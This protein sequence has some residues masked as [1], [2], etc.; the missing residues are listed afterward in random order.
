MTLRTRLAFWF[1]GLLAITIVFFSIAVFGL[2]W[3]SMVRDVDD[4]LLDTARLISE[5][6]LFTDSPTRQQEEPP[7]IQLP[8]LDFVSA[9][10]TEV[11]V[12]L[13]D[14][15]SSR[16]IYSSANLLNYSEA[17]DPE[18]LNTAEEDAFSTV[19]IVGSW[20]R[21]H[22]SPI[23]NN[24]NEVIGS[25][26]VAR[27]MEGL[28]DATRSLFVVVLGCAL[29]TI[30]GAVIISR[31]L[32]QRLLEPI[33]DLTSAA[34]RIAG[35]SDLST[36]LT[37]NGPNDELGRLIAVFNRMM[38][39]LQNVFRIQQRFVADISHE[40]RTP[41]TGIMG[42]VD[43]MRR[44]G[45]DEESLNAIHTDT[46][47]MSRLVHD[48]LMLARADSGGTPIHPMIL[49]ADAVLSGAVKSAIHA[50]EQKGLSLTLDHIEPLQVMGDPQQIKQLLDNIIDNAIRFTPDGG[51]ITITMQRVDQSARIE[52]TD[53]GIGI[54]AEHQ[55]RIFD[56]FYQVDTA[57]AQDGSGGFGLG[58]S[59]ARWIAE[60]HHGSIEVRSQLGFGT[61]FTIHL[62]LANS[63]HEI[64][65]P[66][67]RLS[68]LQLPRIR[69]ND[70]RSTAK[71][72]PITASHRRSADTN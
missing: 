12:W 48:L 19:N 6:S 67:R 64:T 72:K 65:N 37:W 26:Q 14:G 49:D 21:V 5:D 50:A 2:M 36:R 22:T 30:V 20:W 52:V 24:H 38:E 58:L 61:T 66:S 35:A 3:W 11:Q 10:G 34:S 16:R 8:E 45:A 59:V 33:Q 46:A 53:T 28:Y 39:R 13:T 47:R 57:R 18:L 40:L 63:F 54:D 60:A 70:A 29:I 71:E 43:L 44:Y 68:D 31:W 42:N 1:A 17:L 62:P 25:I 51:Q 32:A 23:F 9:S 7:I 27:S 69:Y 56:R 4:A 41:L 55:Q 15:Q